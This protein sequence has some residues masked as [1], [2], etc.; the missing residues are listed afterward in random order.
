M[1]LTCITY[2]LICIL[3]LHILEDNLWRSTHE[4]IVLSINNKASFHNGL[5]TF[6]LDITINKIKCRIYRLQQVI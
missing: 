6:E 3:P 4:Y 1:Y 5:K 2:L